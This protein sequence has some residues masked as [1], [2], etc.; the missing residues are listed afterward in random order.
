MIE[1]LKAVLKDD[2]VCQQIKEA[3][4]Q[5]EVVKLVTNAVTDKCKNLTTEDVTQMLAYVGLHKLP[6]LS[7]EKLLAVAGRRLYW[8]DITCRPCYTDRCK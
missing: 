6:E 2:E 4:T 1:E 5:D 3:K 8:T 7:E